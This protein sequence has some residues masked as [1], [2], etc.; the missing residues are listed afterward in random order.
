MSRL[1]AWSLYAERYSRPDASAAPAS[2]TARNKPVFLRRNVRRAGAAVGSATATTS[3]EG[4]PVAARRRKPPRL[5]DHSECT[6]H[7]TGIR[8]VTCFYICVNK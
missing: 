8:L 6:L 1:A 2:G 5:H 4:A 3:C 7:T